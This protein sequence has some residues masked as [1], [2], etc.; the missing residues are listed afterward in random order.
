MLHYP[1]DFMHGIR[2]ALGRKQ[3]FAMH[4]DAS[5][6]LVSLL[7][8]TFGYGIPFWF[9]ERA[10]ARTGSYAR[11]QA[12]STLGRFDVD[13][14]IG[15]RRF[16]FISDDMGGAVIRARDRGD[17]LEALR[18]ALIEDGRFVDRTTVT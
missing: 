5:G 16:T 6:A 1:S 9:L 7:L 15:D 14:R 18:A 3:P 10:L 11:G 17:D 12:R 8:P 4:R 13:F 2:F